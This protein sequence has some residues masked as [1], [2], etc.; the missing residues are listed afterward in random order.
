[1][2]L[3]MEQENKMNLRKIVRNHIERRTVKNLKKE[4]TKHVSGNLVL[5]NGCGGG[6]FFY[7]KHKN[8]EIYGI[9]V[10]ETNNYKGMFKLASSTN[11]SF[12]DN[13]FDCVVFAGVIQYI[14]DYEKSLKEIKRVLKSNGRLIISTVNRDSLL[15][16]LKIIGKAP[17]REAG[18]F[19]I[20]S[21]EELERL[22]G[23]YR[24]SIENEMGADYF[25]IPKDLCSNS[26]II[27]KNEK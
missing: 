18:E 26:L 14:K 11:I 4:I 3:F 7:E 2:A 13:S 12:G 17:K 20:L 27:C 6:S 10:R 19:Q 22:L 1:M 15:R 24:F 21:Y 25:K 16:R 5:D 23:K 9:D 8:K